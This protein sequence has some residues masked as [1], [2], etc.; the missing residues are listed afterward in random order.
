[1]D[2]M[3]RP[4]TLISVIMPVFN[5]ENRVQHAINSIISQKF[6]DWELLVVN[7]GSTDNTQQ[8]IKEYSL[9]D[10][11]IRCVEIRH[12]GVSAARNAGLRRARGQ[13]FC[14]LDSDNSWRPNF[15]G[16]I[17]KVLAGRLR[18]CCYTHMNVDIV[19]EKNKLVA[20][21]KLA[22]S[23]SRYSCL[24]HNQI[25]LNAFAHTSDL[26]WI[27]GG[28]NEEMSRLVDWDFI[29]RLTTT[30]DPIQIE[31][32]LVDYVHHRER[33]RV[34][35]A[36]DY[37]T[38][39]VLLA[40]RN[41]LRDSIEIH[42]F[43][44]CFSLEDIEKFSFKGMR[45]FL[46][47]K[48]DVFGDYK[49]NHHH[50]VFWKWS[51]WDDEIQP[52]LEGKE[53]NLERASS[54]FHY[55]TALSF[56]ELEKIDDVVNP[57]KKG[58]TQQFHFQVVENQKSKKL[59]HKLRAADVKN[60]ETNPADSVFVKKTELRDGDSIDW[61]WQQLE[62]YFHPKKKY[63]IAIG[64][65]AL[66]TEDPFEWGDY[67]FAEALVRAF[68]SRQI[69]AK[70]ICRDEIMNRLEPYD[71]FLHLFGIDHPPLPPKNG[72]IRLMWIISHP[73]KVRVEEL[74]KYDHVFI[75]SESYAKSLKDSSPGLRVSFLPQCTDV[76]VFRPLPEASINWDGVFVG[77]SRKIH[78]PAV[79]YAA[80]SGRSLA[81]WGNGWKNILPEEAL[82]PGF[83][84]SDEVCKVYQMGKVVLNDHWEDQ[85]NWGIVNN[86]IFD[87]LACNRIPLSDRNKGLSILFP[88]L[89]TFDNEKEFRQQFNK[90]I[91]GK[92]SC[93]EDWGR[94]IVCQQHTFHHRASE[95]LTKLGQ[96]TEIFRPDE[97]PEYKRPRVLF[98]AHSKSANTARKRCF[99]IAKAID[100]IL[101]T[102]AIV[103][104]QADLR[105]M[106][107]FDIVIFQRW[108]NRN[109]I[110]TIHFFDCISTL[111]EAGVAF[112]YE[113]DDLVF[114][115]GNWLPL[116][117]IAASD[118]VTVSTSELAKH[119]GAFHPHVHVLPNA[120]DA[121]R[122]RETRPLYLS[123]NKK[124]VLVASTDGMGTN[125]LIRIS[126]LLEKQ[127][128]NV[129]FHFVNN[130][131][132]EFNH[133][134]I[135]TYPMMS[136]D[137]L[138][139]FMLA[140][141]VILNLSEMSDFLD[142]RLQIQKHG[143][144]FD[145]FINSKSEIKYQYAG[146]A[147]KPIITSSKPSIYRDV[148][149]DNITGYIIDEDEE[150]VDCL[151]KLLSDRS[152]LE[153]VGKAAYEDVIRSHTLAARWPIY[154]QVLLEINARRLDKNMSRHYDPIYW[155]SRNGKPLSPK[156]DQE[157]LNQIKA[158]KLTLE[159]FKRREKNRVD[160]Q[161]NDSLKST[162]RWRIGT[163]IV[164]S[165]RRPHTMGFLPLK[166]L[167]NVVLS[168]SKTKIKKKRR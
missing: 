10:E 46:H 126:E 138:F 164:E 161:N 41:Q 87:V 151:D 104:D 53:T 119:A 30:C 122:F 58:V 20:N 24:R 69:E 62:T 130:L 60:K 150:L 88:E 116:D 34:S 115:Y 76:D 26:Y 89:P 81:V 93:S 145:D 120:V 96:I 44:Y 13:I 18:S 100:G 98:I 152:K 22:K 157:L 47:E 68:E 101:V 158:L 135:T 3:D 5:R 110:R 61:V 156:P 102:R 17:Y 7:D 141:D 132:E 106:V 50:V 28:F 147:R 143:Y 77:N 55:D 59:Y 109:A 85:N 113:I 27:H 165:I 155:H 31:E 149:I 103:A 153:E 166:I 124:H 12:A 66:S 144:S 11:R 25:D 4:K 36:A 21:T 56:L 97:L 137:K 107:G 99:E 54:F 111:R 9:K 121:D 6:Q 139:S 117:F 19:D 37:K 51:E 23:F 15:L 32:I 114:H 92:Y 140:S 162:L 86:R 108:T 57:I 168:W 154:Q 29:L 73:D 39:R 129:A 91:D 163:D 82:Q 136:I 160:S 74:A 45:I 14:Y 16:A 133:K 64:I 94:R 127:Q 38:N 35:M 79:C 128:P 65:Q 125:K 80:K 84:R 72:Q 63:R 52:G 123:E 167:R 42:F 48:E 1:M 148:I 49:P 8:V 146:L 112:V 78:R 43:G 71:I 83:L 95:I 142:K 33:H 118:A 90:L 159:G 75:A 70:I 2:R 40:M 105:S 67:Q 134:L 131:S